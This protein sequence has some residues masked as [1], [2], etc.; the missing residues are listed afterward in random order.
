[1]IKNNKKNSLIS[2]NVEREDVEKTALPRHKVLLIFVVFVQFLLMSDFMMLMPMAP[3]IALDLN[4]K[5]EHFA[6]L[7]GA[8][9]AMAVISGLFGAVILDK[10]DQRKTVIILLTVHAVLMFSCYWVES[11]SLLFVLRCLAGLISAPLAAILL[12]FIISNFSVADRGK[13]MAKMALSFSLSAI[14][15]VPLGLELAYIL[16][17]RLA[18]VV[19]AVPLLLMAFA[20]WFVLPQNNPSSVAHSQR[21]SDG[22]SD[23]RSESQSPGHPFSFA[24]LKQQPTLLIGLL[25]MATTTFSVFLFIPHLSSIFQFNYGL[26]REDI[27]QLY[28]LGGLV[29]IVVTQVFGAFIAQLNLNFVSWTLAI[30]TIVVLFLGFSSTPWL[31]VFMVFILFMSLNSLRNLMVQYIVSKI[32][33]P[34]ARTGYMSALVSVR[35]IFTGLASVVSSFILVTTPAQSLANVDSLI[36]LSTLTILCMPIFIMFLLRSTKMI[37]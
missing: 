33:Q 18:F 23:N 22:R 30:A 35:N 29:T 20:S 16:G 13:A 8:Y 9:T 11:F 36:W 2:G 15:G 28:L 7:T 25:L 6:W 31:P 37:Y 3:D 24:L 1:M 14:I 34:A 19:M 12:S 10:V 32:P 5:V 21:D 26:A 27:G 4:F 17:W